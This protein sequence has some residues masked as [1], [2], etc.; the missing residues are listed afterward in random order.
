MLPK[1]T[2]GT[3]NHTELKFSELL[4]YVQNKI[5]VLADKVGMIFIASV[6]LNS[7]V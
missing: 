3:E 6:A 7:V 4:L 2:F 5:Q 1:I